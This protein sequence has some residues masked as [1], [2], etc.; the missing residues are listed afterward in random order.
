MVKDIFS[1]NLPEDLLPGHDPVLVLQKV[2][3]QLKF[4]EFQA[5]LPAVPPD[6]TS[7]YVEYKA[8]DRQLLTGVTRRG[9]YALIHKIVFG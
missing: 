9:N 2:F 8:R 3:K 4:P 1:P 6:F 7:I 5:K